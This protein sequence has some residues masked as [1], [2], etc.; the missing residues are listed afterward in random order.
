MND[1]T[2]VKSNSKQDFYLQFT[3]REI[4]GHI[5]KWTRKNLLH[6]LISSLNTTSIGEVQ[7]YC[8]IF[9]GYKWGRLNSELE[10][11]EPP[12]K[13]KS[14]LTFLKLPVVTCSYR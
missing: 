3:S 9:M 7:S 14:G 4:K 12:D 5:F 10:M 11:P 6:L 2:S 1:L 13:L 8:F